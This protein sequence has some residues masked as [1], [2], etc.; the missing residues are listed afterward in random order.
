MITDAITSIVEGGLVAI[1]GAAFL[2]AVMKTLG[3]R[4]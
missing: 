4:F 1:I 2:R 3:I